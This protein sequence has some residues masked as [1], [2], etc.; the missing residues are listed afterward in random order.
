[1]KEITSSEH[2]TSGAESFFTDMAALL[3]DRDGVQLSSVSSPQSVACYQAKGVASNLQLRLVLIPLSNGCLLG[4]L[5]WLDWR[6]ID[7]VC[8]YVNEAFD[9]LVMASAG[10]WK[11]Q[12][13]SAET[14]CLKGFEALVK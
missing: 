11:K 6:G 1:M 8:C 3:S 13:E 10:I 5:S 4:R 7:H 14:L 2:F 12:I 9:C